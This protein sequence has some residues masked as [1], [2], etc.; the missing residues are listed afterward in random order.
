[1]CLRIC[2]NNSS[3]LEKILSLEELLEALLYWFRRVHN[4]LKKVDS[5][6]NSC[7][8]EFHLSCN[9]D[10]SGKGPMMT[11]LCNA[12]LLCL[13]AFSRNYVLEEAA[14]IAEELSVTKMSSLSY[15]GTPCCVLS[16]SHFKMG[17]S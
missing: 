14:L 16:K 15:P 4:T 2:T 17:S 8:M 10:I 12:I 3:W 9:N 6:S 11:F 13:T 5:T 7:S 1:V